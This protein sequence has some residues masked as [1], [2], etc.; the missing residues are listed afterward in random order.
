MILAAVTLVP[1]PNVIVVIRNTLQ[2]GIGEGTKTIFGNLVALL[3]MA[4]LAAF[5]LGSIFILYPSSLTTVRALGATYLL[6]V[7]WKLYCSGRQNLARDS[8]EM[9]NGDSVDRSTSIK[10][11][12]F[13]SV[14]NPKAILFLMSVFPQHIN[15]DDNR[16]QQFI[17]LFATLVCVVFSI[18]FVYALFGSTMRRSQH[19]K[20]VLAATNL[21]A[22]TLLVVFSTIIWISLL[23]N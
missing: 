5:G 7:A 18:H 11:G 13:V 4:A 17:I 1:G 9:P 21:T 12:L 16:V 19:F 20:I 15:P 14:S 2:G 22:A 3:F 10:D 23:G 6:Y 8:I